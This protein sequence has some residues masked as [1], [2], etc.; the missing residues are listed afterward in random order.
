MRAKSKSPAPPVEPHPARAV[1]GKKKGGHGRF[2]SA[3]KIDQPAPAH[4]PSKFTGL[5]KLKPVGCITVNVLVCRGCYLA[6]W[7]R[8]EVPPDASEERRT[9]AL[10]RKYLLAVDALIQSASFKNSKRVEW[11][12]AQ[13]FDPAD[14]EY[15]RNFYTVNED[16]FRATLR[17]AK[18]NLGIK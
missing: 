18:R 13:G 7:S 17:V 6:D 5:C 15:W 9:A 4:S 14:V 3:E 10:R 16:T 11:L 1:F 2:V 12:L 8:Y